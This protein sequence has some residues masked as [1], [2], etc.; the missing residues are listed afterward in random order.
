MAHIG[1]HVRSI[2][3]PYIGEIIDSAGNMVT[4]EYAVKGASEYVSYRVEEITGVSG[5][6]QHAVIVECSHSREVEF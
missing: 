2:G 5:W 1:D 4:V 3:L 6:S